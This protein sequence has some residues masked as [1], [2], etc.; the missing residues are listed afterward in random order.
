MDRTTMEEEVWL[1]G[2]VNDRCDSSGISKLHTC[3]TKEKDSAR[4][5]SRETLNLQEE[6]SM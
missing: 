1:A 6:T 5:F 4:D 3:V 2:E